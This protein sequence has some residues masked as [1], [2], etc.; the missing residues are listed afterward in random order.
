MAPPNL[1]FLA[2]KVVTPWE[3]CT[4]KDL[5]H[6]IRKLYYSTVPVPGIYA[7]ATDKR[8]YL[9]AIRPVKGEKDTEKLSHPQRKA[10]MS[11][12]SNR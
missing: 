2:R 7:I 4:L 6:N 9:V 8:H 5:P 12:S 3:R 11:M 1:L 10:G